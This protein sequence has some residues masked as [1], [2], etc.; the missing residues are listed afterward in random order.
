MIIIHSLAVSHGGFTQTRSPVMVTFPFLSSRRHLP[1]M[2]SVTLVSEL[3][4]VGAL[5]TSSPKSGAAK[6]KHSVNHW[7]K[8]KT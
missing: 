1:H 7:S 5:T 4:V 2:L 3:D 6:Y 8:V